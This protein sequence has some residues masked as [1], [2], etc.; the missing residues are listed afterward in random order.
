AQQGLTEKD[1]TLVNMAAPD[2]GAAF[3][4]KSINAAVTWE[5]FGTQG[6]KSG[7]KLLLT[8]KDTPGAIVDVLGVGNDV[9]KNRP[10]AVK[11]LVASWFDALE[12]V[13][14]HQAESFKIM[15][16]ASGV[17]VAEFT[18]MWKGVRIPTLAENQTA[19]GTAP[20][21]GSY[22]KTVESMS[23]FMIEQKLITQPVAADSMVSGAFLPAK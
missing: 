13:K 16:K 8:S 23:S 5:P 2:A 10:D 22:R 7:G 4:A 1:V 14:K 3:A 19:L 21:S 11:L 9:L 20:G 15:A 12:Y 6:I 18:E 17:S